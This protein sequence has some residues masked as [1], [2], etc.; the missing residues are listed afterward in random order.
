MVNGK[1]FSFAGE[2]LRE[3]RAR[4]DNVKL[5]RTAPKG[6]SGDDLVLETD[7]ATGGMVV[8]RSSGVAAQAM[9]GMQNFA[10][11]TLGQLEGV[12]GFLQDFCKALHFLGNRNVERALEEVV[13]LG[14][15]SSFS[16][17]ISA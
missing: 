12:E 3:C 10:E 17:W 1:I 15:Y 2:V 11:D 14:G 7:T 9:T 4:S 6:L 5:Y 13:N 8:A 16:S